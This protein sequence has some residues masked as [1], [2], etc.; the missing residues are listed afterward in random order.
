M[1]A[2][3]GK[4]CPPGNPEPE[5]DAEPP[6]AAAPTTRSEK[7]ASLIVA[8]ATVP[9]FR[10]LQYSLQYQPSRAS[11]ARKKAENKIDSEKATSPDGERERGCGVWC[12]QRPAGGQQTWIMRN[13]AHHVVSSAV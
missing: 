7:R 12:R 3:P 1:I 9:R 11:K 4:A 8:G 13:V 5:P 2:P 6:D 10:Y